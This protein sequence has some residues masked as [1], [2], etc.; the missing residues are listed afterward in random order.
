MN[1]Y[2]KIQ[3]LSI[4]YLLSLP[5]AYGGSEFML[6]DIQGGWWSDCEDPA[7]EF[8]IRENEYSGDFVD[9]HPLTLNNKFL[10][11]K[12]GLINGHRINV[13]FKPIT[14]KILSLSKERMVLQHTSDKGKKNEWELLSCLK[15]S[16]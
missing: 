11:F 9:S 6:K 15:N 2:K 1:M 14:Y 12:N 10:T 7:V 4:V 13:S 16:I 8:L 5:N 3:L